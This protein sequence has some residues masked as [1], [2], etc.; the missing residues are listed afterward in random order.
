[1][2]MIRV[3]DDRKRVKK[4]FV[5]QNGL[6]PSFIPF[7]PIAQ[8]IAVK[9]QSFAPSILISLNKKTS[10][11]REVCYCTEACHAFPGQSHPH[12]RTPLT[13]ALAAGLNDISYGQT[14][15]FTRY[16]RTVLPVDG[17]VF[18]VS[19]GDTQDVSK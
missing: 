17:F 15:R 14:V 6:T 19:T 3:A 1:M 5:S 7:L 9:R 18:W 10:L 16:Q 12:D 13:N 2:F 11:H 4:A 8:Q